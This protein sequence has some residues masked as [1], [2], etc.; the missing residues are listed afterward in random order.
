M[1]INQVAAQLYTVRDFIKTPSDIADSLR[2][3]REI[4]YE[5]VQVS[6]MGPIAEEEL[7]KMLD[8]EGLICCATHEP[9]QQILEEPQAIVERLQK[10]GCKFTAVP[11]PGH[12]PLT[13]LDEVKD[14]A[15]RM[16]TAGEVLFNADQVLCYHNHHMEFRRVDGWSILETI[17]DETNPD[18]LQGEIDTYWV[19][20][21]GG[22]PIDWCERLDQRLPLLH[23]KDYGIDPENKVVFSEIGYGN[24]DWA[25]I[26]SAADAS[27]C[28]W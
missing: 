9:T 3:I 25:G 17:Y 22:D 15:A 7:V 23:L 8:G 19:Q 27:G 16:N 18:F 28:Q 26:I 12:N 5:A 6:G 10:L 11:S 20:Y 14:F 21:G 4:G 1:Q 2:K 13:T 24:L